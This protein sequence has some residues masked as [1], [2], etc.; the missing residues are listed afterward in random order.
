MG[1]SKILYIGM[2]ENGYGPLMGPLFVTSVS[3][4]G[5][6]L[7]DEALKS[8]NH[9]SESGIDMRDSKEIFSST[10]KG[11]GELLALGIIHAFKGK[12]PSTFHELLKDLSNY[13]SDLSD[14]QCRGTLRCMPDLPIPRWNS[15]EEVIASGKLERISE[16]IRYALDAYKLEPFDIKSDLV[17]PWRF[18]AEL[19]SMGNKLRVNFS[20]FVNH[21][22][23][24]LRELDSLRDS[25][26]LSR[27]DVLVLSD[28]LGGQ[29][30][31]SGLIVSE[32]FWVL[33][34]E[35]TGELSSYLIRSERKFQVKF[36]K[37]GDSKYWL[38]S[39]SSIV[40]KYLR[41]LSM[42]AINEF[43]GR[44]LGL[45]FH[46]SG[47][48]DRKTLSVKDKIEELQRRGGLPLPVECLIRD[49]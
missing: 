16:E 34:Y 41:E 17:C 49:K 18:N 7:P 23:Y 37:G 46:F 26:E 8:L 12:I 39:A 2:D 32:G 28:K 43:L 3:V 6:Q 27:Y 24:Y 30:R 10:S 15:S 47:Y 48:R 14:L 38:I 45:S 44:E 11:Y 1:L 5:P 35:E 25:S 40:G 22:R 21:W 20:H 42:E 9:G 31:Y 4:L 13:I 33:A 29:K 36:V 19:N